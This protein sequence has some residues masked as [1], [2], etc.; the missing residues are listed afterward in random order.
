MTRRISECFHSSPW[1]RIYKYV[2]CF[3]Q[4]ETF[5]SADTVKHSDWLVIVLSK[6]PHQSID[7]IGSLCTEKYFSAAAALC[8][9]RLSVFM[10]QVVVDN[11]VV[12]YILWTWRLLCHDLTTSGKTHTDLEKRLL[13]CGQ[14]D[15]ER[16]WWRQMNTLSFIGWGDASGRFDGRKRSEVPNGVTLRLFPPEELHARK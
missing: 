2:Q 16:L 9:G 12:L 1:S 8:C 14:R 5:R 3:L 15:G 7:H 4:T 13:W 6:K 10:V 11:Q